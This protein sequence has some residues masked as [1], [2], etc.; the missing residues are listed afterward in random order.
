MFGSDWL[1]RFYV[2]WALLFQIVLILH[3]AL[4]RWR[5]DTAMRYGRMVYALS[6]PAAVLSIFMVLGGKTWSLW[7]GG[8]IYLVWGVYGFWVEYV[9]K[10][11]W[12]SPP[13]WQVFIPYI[14]LY[15]TTVMFYWW[16]LALIDRSLWVGYSV[17]FIASTALNATSHKRGQR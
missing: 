14:L 7:I 1:E 6:I 4:R 3:F 2:I 13:R 17:L 5:F 10:I 8:F 16:P 15:L 11:Q 12:R 9:K